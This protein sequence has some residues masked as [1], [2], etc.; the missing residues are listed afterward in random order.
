MVNSTKVLEATLQ[1]LITIYRYMV[2]LP[3]RGR[4]ERRGEQGVS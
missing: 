3:K 1:Y 2:Y 4:E